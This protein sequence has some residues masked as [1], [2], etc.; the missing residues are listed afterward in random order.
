MLAMAGFTSCDDSFADWAAPST[1]DPEAALEA[2]GITVTGLGIDVDM[3][4][5]NRPDSI[6]VVTIST[7]HEDITTL[8]YD[9]ITVNGCHIR[10][11]LAGT[12]CLEESEI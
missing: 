3:S 8:E 5:A 2:Y 4:D 1:N 11:R 9:A 10:P 6:R 7:S 12:H